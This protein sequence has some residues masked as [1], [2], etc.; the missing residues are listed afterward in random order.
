VRFALEWAPLGL[1]DPIVLLLVAVVCA[2]DDLATDFIQDIKTQL[3]GAGPLAD[4]FPEVCYPIKCLER[5]TARC[6]GQTC[7]GAATRIEWT[8]DTIVLPTIP[9]SPASGFRV[10]AAGITGAIRGLKF[11]R[12][13]GSMV[14]PSFVLIDDPQ[15]NE[16]AKSIMQ[17]GDRIDI[18]DSFV[19]GSSIST[20]DGRTIDPS[21][22]VNFSPRIAPVMPAAVTRNPLAGDPGIVGRTI[23]SD[24]HSI[25][26]AAPPHVW[27]RQRAV[28]RSRHLIG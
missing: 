28:S 1:L 24:V 6:R 22:R 21:A 3:E 5:L 14:R 9:G 13:D 20:N 12:A 23:V 4:D 27:P 8:S 10:T 17:T 16:S 7:G 25:R 18:T 2:I 19:C 11:T 15:T 26:V